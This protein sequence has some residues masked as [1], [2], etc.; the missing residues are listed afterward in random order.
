MKKAYIY[1]ITNKKNGTLYTGV[2]S[3]LI[4]RIYEHKNKIVKGFSSKYDLK[5][6]VYYEM[7]ENIESA[8]IR[9]KQIKAGSRKKKL[10]LINNFNPTWKDLYEDLL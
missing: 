5:N 10:E 9:E 8:I 4:K 2:T 7:F 1:I 3:D 6:L